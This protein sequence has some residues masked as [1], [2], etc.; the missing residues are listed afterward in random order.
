MA[1]L[2]YFCSIA[3]ITASPFKAR[4][5]VPQPTNREKS[6]FYNQIR[7]ALKKKNNALDQKMTKGVVVSIN[8]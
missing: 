7:K 3:T 6:F 5:I 1:K 8:P 2:S 4:G